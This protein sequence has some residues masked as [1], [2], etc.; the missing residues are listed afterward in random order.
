MIIA[1]GAIGALL[2]ARSDRLRA[3][4]AELTATS[5]ELARQAQ[6]LRAASGIGRVAGWSFER[7]ENATI[8]WSDGVERLFGMQPGERTLP[9]QA[10]ALIDEQHDRDRLLDAVLVCLRDGT[11][12][13]GN[14]PRDHERWAPP[15]GHGDGRGDAQ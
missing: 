1:V 8:V 9:E 15:V 3:V 14:L 7:G 6:L 13:R 5:D 11:P 2:I 4:S 10:L 12:L